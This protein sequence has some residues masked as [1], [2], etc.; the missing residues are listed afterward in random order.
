VRD[1]V[2]A[3]R[4]AARVDPPALRA[5]SKGLTQVAHALEHLPFMK[6]G[7]DESTRVEARSV[8][9]RTALVAAVG[10]AMLLLVLAARRRG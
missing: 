4:F 2:D 3:A 7:E 1:L 6:S 10:A 9:S 8:G 5:V